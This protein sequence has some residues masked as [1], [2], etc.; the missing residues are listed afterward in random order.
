MN[1]AYFLTFFFFC[2]GVDTRGRYS[3]RTNRKSSRK[4]GIK[5]QGELNSYENAPSST[6]LA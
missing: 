1:D 5:H 4:T 2:T 6:P 3:N